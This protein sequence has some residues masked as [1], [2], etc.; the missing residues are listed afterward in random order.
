MEKEPRIC[1]LQEPNPKT[2]AILAGLLLLT[3]LVRLPGIAR[4][5]VG[6][7]A[8]KNVVYAMIARNWAEGRSDFRYPTLDCLAGGH[9]SLHML[10][11]PC[12]AYFTGWLWKTLGGSLDVWGRATAIG[13]SLASVMVL[14][15]LVRRRHGPVAAMGAATALAISPVSIVYGQSFML[16]ASLV[17]F[18][19]ATVWCL[20]RWLA[21]GRRAW[22]PAAALCLSLLLLTKIFML[23]ML[24]PL[25]AM[26]VRR[27]DGSTRDP[28][29]SPGE[30]RG[31]GLQG[32]ADVPGRHASSQ[33]PLTLTLSRRERGPNAA[34]CSFLAA[35]ALVLALIPAVA[36]YAHAVRT[37]TD[38]TLAPRIFYSVV[39]SAAVHRPPHPLLWSPDFYRQILDDLAG[40]VLTPLGLSLVLA[41]L[42]H[43][44]WRRYLPWLAA[45][46]LLVAALPLKFHQM[47]YYWMAALPPLTIL[48]GLG[49]QQ[50]HDRLALGWPAIA[51]VLAV[52][53]LFSLRY[54]LRPAMITPPADRAVVHAGRAIQRLTAADEPVV[55]MHGSGIDLLYYC[56]RPGWALSPDTP[57]LDRLLRQYRRQGA[58]YLVVVAEPELR[59]RIGDCPATDKS[60]SQAGGEGYAVYR[61]EGYAVYRLA[62][63]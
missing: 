12:S 38:S 33:F 28:P 58:R 22:L 61:G 1:I 32:E 46:A 56:R 47:N 15:C 51:I 59:K 19:V 26:I 60:G 54:A 52:A 36:W 14:F 6:N 44:A 2:F 23:V 37:A 55:T 43:P 62:A 27:A 5:L 4:P 35:A 8:T 18:T 13:F 7:F 39:D 48:I 34:R 30:G 31:E 41:G 50:V 3:L 11:M 9:R 29:L 40:V 63:P 16:E 10:E 21:G 24:L 45:M 53:L 20:D 57:Q 17:F 25:A 49:W 42:L